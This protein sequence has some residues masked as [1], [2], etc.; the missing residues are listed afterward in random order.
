MFG[1]IAMW[2]LVVDQAYAQ[3]IEKCKDAFRTI[4]DNV[5]LI[6]DPDDQMVQWVMETALETITAAR[7]YQIPVEELWTECILLFHFSLWIS[8]ESPIPQS[9]RGQHTYVGPVVSAIEC[10]DDRLPAQSYVNTLIRVR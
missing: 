4:Y 2:L 3:C 5:D 7:E 1:R 6:P 8:N 9:Q 10:V